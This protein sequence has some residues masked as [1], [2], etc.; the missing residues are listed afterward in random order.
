MTHLSSLRPNL[1]YTLPSMSFRITVSLLLC[2]Q[3]GA[4][5]A[6]KTSPFG[7]LAQ[8]FN[9]PNIESEDRLAILNLIHAYSHLA[10]GLHTEEFAKFFTP[11]GIFE[12]VSY[13]DGGKSLRQRVGTGRSEIVAAM[14]PRHAEFRNKGIQ[15]RHFLTNPVVWE[16]TDDRARV[17]VYLQLHSSERGGPSKLVATGRYEGVAIKTLEGWRMAEW[18]ILSDQQIQ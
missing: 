13:G 4:T 16:Q 5:S 17:S 8:V 10:D 7:D 15:R 3:L 2:L 11:D 18:T 1:E 14:Q 9:P 6:P 12:I